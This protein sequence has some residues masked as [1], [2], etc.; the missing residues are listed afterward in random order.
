MKNIK[1]L[2]AVLLTL[3]MVLGCTSI[4]IASSRE[5]D[6]M[7]ST[8]L[9]LEKN[10]TNSDGKSRHI[11]VS[12]EKVS[13]ADSYKIQIAD[14]INFENAVSKK[15]LSKQGL[16]WNFAEVPGELTDTYFIRVAPCFVYG[17][18]EDGYD[19][20]YGQWSNVVIAPYKEIDWSNIKVPDFN[21]PYIPDIDWSKV[22]NIDW[23]KI[24]FP[25]F[26]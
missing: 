18:T 3:I 24:E 7:K 9:T 8:V 25:K 26:K 6:K 16:Y 21:L 13:G 10:N 23:S 20:E 14:N 4:A 19:Y 22:I 12:W 17:K 15:R 5:E 11:K 1:K 2:L